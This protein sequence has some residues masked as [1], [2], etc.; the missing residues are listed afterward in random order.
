MHDQ[1]TVTT[2][3][4]ENRRFAGTGGVSQGNH[5]RR[6]QPAFRDT[7]TGR[8]ELA[9]FADGRPAPMHLLDGLPHE[10]ITELDQAGRVRAVI[11]SVVSGFVRDGIFYTREQAAAALH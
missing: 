10:W 1:L 11:Q 2:L 7:T 8:T 9:R 4:Q 6:F 5:H 3:K